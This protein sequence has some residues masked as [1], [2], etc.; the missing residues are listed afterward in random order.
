[1]KEIERRLASPPTF[2]TGGFFQNGNYREQQFR[3]SAVWDTMEN[4]H[5][6]I[7]DSSGQIINIMT[8][9]QQTFLSRFSLPTNFTKLEPFFVSG[10]TVLVGLWLVDRIVAFLRLACSHGLCTAMAA[11][12]C[13]E[14]RAIGAIDDVYKMFTQRPSQQLSVNLNGLQ[15]RAGQQQALV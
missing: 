3:T 14:N 4:M 1:M 8:P 12:F 10:L 5:S 11:L 2:E 13:P 6:Y 9:E 15:E 7:Q